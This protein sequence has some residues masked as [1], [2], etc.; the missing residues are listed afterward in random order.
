MLIPGKPI[1]DLIQQRYSCRAYT[2]TPIAVEQAGQLRAFAGSITSGPLGTPLRFELIVA[3][4]PD[5]KELKGLGTYGA[6]RNPAGFI[7]GA[8]GPGPMALIDYGYALETI[9][10]YTTGLGLGTCWLGGN[11]TRSAFSRLIHP[12]NEECI[13]AV[14]AVGCPVE[15]IR[16]HDRL[17]QKVSSDTRRPWESL[18]FQ[19]GFRRPL[20]VENASMYAGPLE[21]LRLAPS[22]HNHQP[23]RVV[24]DG[25]CYHIY[26][27]R[28]PGYGPGSLSFWLLGVV[29]LQRMEIGIAMCHF[30][31]AAGEA[32]LEGRWEV[33]DPGL[34]HPGEVPEYVVTWVAEN[35]SLT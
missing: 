35:V 25:G 28:T 6:I 4:E 27:Q 26:L 9:L 22:G 3:V 14:A 1:F 31:L 30:A 13:P 11:F 17:R 32:G 21:M 20:S 24:Q 33:R 12:A 10:L 23:W 5:R 8:A 15:N 29:D 16:S 19:S 2:K 18:F 34:S 7:T